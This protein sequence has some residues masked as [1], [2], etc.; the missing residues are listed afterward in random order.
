MQG[1]SKNGGEN[2]RR[3]V[4]GNAGSEPPLQ[5]KQKSSKL[6]R[7]QI[8]PAL[9]VLVG[10]I[11]LEAL[12]QRNDRRREDH[13]GDRQSEIE[14]HEAHSVLV[15]LPRGGE[16]GDRAGLGRHDRQANRQPSSIA[17]PSQVR[18]DAADA[19]RSP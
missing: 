9:Q 4:D 12:V 17:T 5:E 19:A 3:S 1:P 8:E 13:H 18:V 10:R 14:L 16:K 11:D 6:A 2:Y 15:T 7:L